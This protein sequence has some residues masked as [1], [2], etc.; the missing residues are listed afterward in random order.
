MVAVN[1]ICSNNINKI[2]TV[3]AVSLF[4]IQHIAVCPVSIKVHNKIRIA[5]KII[6][7]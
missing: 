1:F 6:N 5:I 4:H 7:G 3:S 2:N